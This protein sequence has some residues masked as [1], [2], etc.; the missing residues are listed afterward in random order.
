MQDALGFVVSTAL[1]VALR[2]LGINAEN[3]IANALVVAVEIVLSGILGYA[4]SNLFFGRPTVG[5]IWKLDSDHVESGRPDLQLAN[6]R[7]RVV[8]LEVKVEG[9]GKLLAGLIFWHSKNNP[10]T[11]V[12]Q[13]TPDDLVLINRQKSD[14]R[15]T[16][17]VDRAACRIRFL[18][19]KMV[20]GATIASLEFSVKHRT[21]ARERDTP[22]DLAMHLEAN[23]L[24][25]FLSK[26]VRLDTGVSGFQVRNS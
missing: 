1:F 4:L 14:S 21:R 9:K 17:E 18:D 6:G 25:R 26:L 10:Y 19:R 8:H 7:K 13:M 23:G 15:Q 11:V 5:L 3:D 24:G 2:A 12:C 22:L 20:E 16:V